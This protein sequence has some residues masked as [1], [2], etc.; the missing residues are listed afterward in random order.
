MQPA[1]NGKWNVPSLLH[2]A[3]PS[4]WIPNC[5]CCQ[6]VSLSELNKNKT[7][8][9]KLAFSS[10]QTGNLKH[11]ECLE[12]TGS[13]KGTSWCKFM[14]LRNQQQQVLQAKMDLCHHSS[15]WHS[16]IN[17]FWGDTEIYTASK[18]ADSAWHPVQSTS[19]AREERGVSTLWPGT[20]LQWHKRW[21]LTWGCAAAWSEC[22]DLSR[23]HFLMPSNR[24]H[25]Q[26]TS[27]INTSIQF[28]IL[29]SAWQRTQSRHLI[30]MSVCSQSLLFHKL[31]KCCTDEQLLLLSICPDWK[32]PC[33]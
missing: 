27:C 26:N 8:P 11:V 30:N 3:V 33:T 18:A 5:H 32:L 21:Q 7:N 2:A 6:S 31:T 10:V 24:H 12:I 29:L 25:A 14:G 9:N 23:C 4:A 22:S 15:S 1:R 28:W 16:E 17:G 20:A 13:S 19:A